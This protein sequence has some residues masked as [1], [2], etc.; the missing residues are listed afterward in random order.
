[1]SHKK[2]TPHPF[3]TAQ[4]RVHKVDAQDG[5]R[6]TDSQSDTQP[7]QAVRLFALLGGVLDLG[8]DAEGRIETE[9]TDTM[10]LWVA[11]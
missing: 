9:Q 3:S 11:P 4:Q 2:S 5:C 7:G 6:Q 8:V 10:H 1:M